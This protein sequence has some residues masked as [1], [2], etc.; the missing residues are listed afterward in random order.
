MHVKLTSHIYESLH[1]NNFFALGISSVYAT[2]S[3]IS[4][5][6]APFIEDVCV[7]TGTNSITNANF[8]V[9]I[10]SWSTSSSGLPA[11]ELLEL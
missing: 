11:A 10:T 3:T 6:L 1:K 8:K 5:D 2:K 9:L 7:V 4:M